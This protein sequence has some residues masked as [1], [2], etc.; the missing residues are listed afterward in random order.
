LHSRQEEVR[1]CLINPIA[2]EQL[3]GL[4]RP[5]LMHLRAEV[6]GPQTIFHIPHGH[7]PAAAAADDQ[8]LEER[9]ARA[10]GP[11]ALFG[12]VRPVIIELLDVTDKLFPPQ[13]AHV[14]LAEHDRPACRRH[15][16]A[17][18]FDPRRF[19]GQEPRATL[20]APVD[21]RAGV[22][23]GVEHGEDAGVA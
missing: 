3:T 16:T 9:A 10:H 7:P 18:R 23:G 19:P 12:A 11:R 20:R 8:A 22:E 13:I 6:N 5:V 21:I 14:M 1:Y 15:P 2:P 17:A 4:A